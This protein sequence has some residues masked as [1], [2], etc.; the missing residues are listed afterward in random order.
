MLC[1]KIDCVLHTLSIILLEWNSLDVAFLKAVKQKSKQRFIIIEP[2][3]IY[4][5]DK[6][7][8]PLANRRAERRPE[9][10]PSFYMQTSPRDILHLLHL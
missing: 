10:L 1:D 4:F 2:K 9:L 5:V 8:N 6:E 7:A 3:R